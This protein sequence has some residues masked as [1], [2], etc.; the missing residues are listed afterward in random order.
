MKLTKVSQLCQHSQMLA[1]ILHQDTLLETA[2]QNFSDN[3]FVRGIFVVDDANEL[4]GVVNSHDFLPWVRMHLEMSPFGPTVPVGKM[5]RLLLAERILDMAQPGSHLAAVSMDASLAD[6]LDMMFQHNLV[7]IPVLD[8]NGRI[9]NDLRLSEV[10][11]Y[12]MKV[13][14]QE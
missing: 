7:D 5:R 2:I 10:L 12:T 9:V 3:P 1:I 4:V 8:E 13:S 11:A 14:D 6:V